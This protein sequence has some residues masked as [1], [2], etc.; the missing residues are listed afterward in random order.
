M[1]GAG[2]VNLRP[3]RTEWF[4][5]SVGDWPLETVIRQLKR[6]ANRSP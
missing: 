5:I 3:S 2:G 4:R 6:E 1:F